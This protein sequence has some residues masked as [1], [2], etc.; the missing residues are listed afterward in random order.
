[1]FVIS[2]RKAAVT[3]NTDKNT[4]FIPCE[5][6]IVNVF[7]TIAVLCQNQHFL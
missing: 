5:Y 3:E 4:F 1:M 6:G 7:G 2:V